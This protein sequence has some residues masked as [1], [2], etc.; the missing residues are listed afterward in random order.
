MKLLAEIRDQDF[1]PAAPEVDSSGYYQRHA[2]RAVVIDSA[3]RVALLHVTGAGYYKLPG[4]GLEK[5]EDV[6]AA[7]DREAMEEIGC[8]IEV[9]DEVGRTEEH[10][11]QA[12]FSQ[13]SDCYLARQVGDQQPPSFTDEEQQRGFVV[14]WFPD[15]QSAIAAAEACQPTD[16]EGHF[17]KHRDLIFLR[18]AQATLAQS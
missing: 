6:R 1:D 15:M 2:A 10:R 13:I 12:Q 17:I 18:A 7:L 11:D 5:D 8:H 14:E 3:G 9:I 16:Y 4:G